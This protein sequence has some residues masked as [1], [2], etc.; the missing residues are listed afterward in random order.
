LKN[1][2]FSNREQYDDFKMRVYAIVNNY[3]KRPLKPVELFLKKNIIKPLKSGSIIAR[4]H[5]HRIALK[6]FGNICFIGITGSCGKTTTTELISSILENEGPL[7]K[8][9]DT[10]TTLFIAK[11]LLE[12]SHSDRFCVTEVSAHRPGAI[13][14]S[15]KLLRPDIGVVTHIGKDHHSNYRNLEMTAT[16][17]AKLVESLPQSGTVVL[18]ADDPYV[19]A[20]RKRTAAKTIT[21]GSSDKAM[22]RGE[23]VCCHWPDLM[24]LDVCFEG[25]R[26][27][28]QT[29]L[30]GVHWA[31]AVLAALSTGIACGVELE[32]G[33][34]ALEAFEPLPSRMSQ[35]TTPD[36]VVFIRDD[37]KAPLWTVKACLDFLRDAQA[38]RKFLV[39]GSISDT[40]K[41]Y[42][43]RYRSVIEQSGG[44]VDRIFFVGDHARTALKARAD[45][46][47]D[48]IMA[49]DNLYS[50]NSYLA[51]YL[52]SGDLV[53]LKG[54]KKIDH[55]QR[56][57][58]SRTDDIKCWRQD[59]MKQRFC[60]GCHLQQSPFV[61]V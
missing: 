12:V 3:F 28:L 35:H 36:G 52:K 5:L 61:R 14:K 47:D 51:D 16:E 55:L 29:Q 1:P 56:L 11:A 46:D 10:N 44:A 45:E 15:V 19:Y 34:R 54:S 21:Y 20:M 17:K 8:S 24:S 31:W 60:T 40:P 9:S 43:H 50:L 41:G 53:L 42:F 7:C 27:H 4:A 57:I 49:F 26:Y 58:L 13:G 38:D 33:L 30:L 2:V 23:N 25:N 59:C 39:V 37:N 18:N 6:H 48:S 22:V 32:R